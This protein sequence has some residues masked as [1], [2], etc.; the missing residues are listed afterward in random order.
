[1]AT[2]RKSKLNEDTKNAYRALRDHKQTQS[3]SY[4][5]SNPKAPPSEA[6]RYATTPHAID[7]LI[8]DAWTTIRQGNIKDPTQHVQ[9]F[10][11]KYK[12]HIFHR[13][14]YQLD[15]IDPQAFYNHLQQS[16]DSAPSLEGW[17]T[18]ELKLLPLS[19]ISIL[20]SFL[21]RV[22][23]EGEWP[24]NLRHAKA[25]LLYKTTPTQAG[26]HDLRI[27]IRPAYG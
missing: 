15:P 10:Y 22:E 1:M 19:A 2:Q 6:P 4:L 12:H 8:R 3:I 21:N 27:P 25:T 16:Q 26:P 24:D 20:V 13:Q 5:R 18:A 7:A 17:R 11:H 9:Q 23:K 14:P